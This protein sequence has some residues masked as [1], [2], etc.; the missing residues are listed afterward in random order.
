VL[1]CVVVGCAS[2]SIAPPTALAPVP[3]EPF[4]IDG[5][6]SARR[7]NEAVAVSFAW[8]HASPRDEIVIT[9]PLGA[10]VA[11][12]SGDASTRSVE[13]RGADGRVDVAS[14]WASLTARSVGFPLPVAGLVY[15][16]RGAAREDAPHVAEIDAAGR[17]ASCA[18]TAARSS[19][20][21]RTIGRAGLPSSGSPATMWNC[22][23]SSI[24]GA[25]RDPL[26]QPGAR[27]HKDPMRTLTVP[28][29]A[30]LNLFLHVTGRRA[31]GYHLLE[32]LLVLIDVGDTITLA[33][34]DDGAIVR[35]TE[36]AG[37][38]PEG[39]LT[40]RAATAL[41]R[42]TGCSLG[43]D[44]AVTKRIPMGGGL[45][46][47]SSDAATVLL[48]LN[49]LWGANLPRE[50][51]IRIGVTLGADV[52]FFLGG[53]PALARGIGERLTPVSLPTAWVAVIAPAIAVA[54]GS[55][56]AAP[57]LTRDAASAKMDVF[58]EGYGRN[59]LQA[60]AIARHPDIGVALGKLGEH[61][62]FARMT[63]SGGC[64]FAPFASETEA[65]AAIDARPPGM[66]GFVARTLARHPLAAFA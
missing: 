12:L 43:A 33:R 45:G 59:D 61:S 42:E 5:R 39:D 34:R 64:V 1:A 30:K 27:R 31:D 14:D 25:R 37:V 26:A 50:E 46:G 13:V 7:G 22:A 35:T 51:L 9:T 20:R 41:Q 6:L 32:T 18:R 48:A 16:V 4:A 40:I 54:T 55:I 53:G 52:P 21:T 57:E 10:A 17:V 58:S 44:V 29:P 60:V 24:A 63:G 56:F 28:A 19:T 2:T 11:Q 15:W 8:T 65:R 49:R 38:A 3:D 66:Q 23:S 36:L 62:R 47:G